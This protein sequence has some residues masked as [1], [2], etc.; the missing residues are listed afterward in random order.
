MTTIRH[1]II[2]LWCHK[3]RWYVC[4]SLSDV[5]LLFCYSKRVG[6]LSWKACWLNWFQTFS[7]SQGGRA[8]LSSTNIQ[9]MFYV[10]HCIT[11]LQNILPALPKT[12]ILTIQASLKYIFLIIARDCK[13]TAKC[14]YLWKSMELFICFVFY[15]A[16]LESV[17]QANIWKWVK[18]ECVNRNLV[19]QRG[20]GRENMY[21]YTRVWP[22]LKP[23]GKQEC[24]RTHLL[25]IPIF[26]TK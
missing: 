12:R 10:M 20:N 24:L 5:A 21:I 2:K 25:I 8:S 15:A 13:R 7:N 26:W 17:M 16:P 18:Y 9:R 6:G 11:A 19:E 1:F 3:G 4:Q 23:V 14:G 22:L